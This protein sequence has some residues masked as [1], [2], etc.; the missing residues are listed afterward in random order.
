VLKDRK[1]NGRHTEP[2]PPA[3][4]VRRRSQRSHQAILSAATELLKENGYLGVSIEAIA[5]SAGVGKQT[6]YRWWP[7]KA[8]VVMEAV[9]FQLAR[10]IP[11][12]DTGSVESDLQAFLQRLFTVFATTGAGRTVAGLMAEAQTNPEFAQA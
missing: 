8:D 9:A 6:I 10:D 1:N 7:S 4:P 12:P 3:S 5:A 11:V 2:K